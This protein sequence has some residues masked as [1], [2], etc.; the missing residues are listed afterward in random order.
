DVDGINRT[1]RLKQLFE[2][3]LIGVERQI[4]DKQLATHDDSRPSRALDECGGH[5]GRVEGGIERNSVGSRQRC[6]ED[7][8]AGQYT[9]SGSARCTACREE[10]VPANG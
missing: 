1:D 3:T 8:H 5:A 7:L 6:S 9:R 4:P 2:A 10:D